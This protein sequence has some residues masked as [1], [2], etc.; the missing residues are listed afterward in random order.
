MRGQ[1]ELVLP[2]DGIAWSVLVTAGDDVLLEHDP[3][4]PLSGASL[5]KLLLLIEVAERIVRGEQ[6][7][8]ALLRRTADD[9]VADSGLWQLLAVDELSVL[10]LA[11]LVG[12]VSDNLAT[13][14][15]LR[16]VGLDAVAE[17]GRRLGLRRMA[18]HDRV[19]DA[20]EPQHP[21]RLS[22]VTARELVMVMDAVSSGE[23]DA[24]SSGAA[25]L[26]R[27]WLAAGCD[28][29]MVAY[30]FG[31]DPLAHRD[32]DRGVRLLNKTGTDSTAR[33]DTGVLTRQDDGERTTYAAVAQWDPDGPD[34][35][36]EVLAAMQQIGERIRVVAT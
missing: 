17:R 30:A 27:G 13:N 23:H 6:E 36:D 24:L 5:G 11:V 35:R 1:S 32:P 25:A 31:L 7:P 21:P 8:R 26:V 18:L 28:L 33:G 22:T 10:D 34:R 2:Q 16:H 29:S 3:D 20:R 14:V 15:L 4:R 12:S 19:R 9:L